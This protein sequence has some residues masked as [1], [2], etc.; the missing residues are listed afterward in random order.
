MQLVSKAMMRVS[1]FVLCASSHHTILITLAFQVQLVSGASP[2]A[3]WVSAYLWDALLFFVLS[4]LVMLTFA[5]YGRD[6]SK[7][8]Q[9]FEPSHLVVHYT[10][11]WCSVYGY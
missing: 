1:H 5:A 9:V 4:C 2:L 8:R 11:W 10:A 6:A 3:Y 7:V